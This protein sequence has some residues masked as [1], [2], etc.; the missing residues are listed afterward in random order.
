MSEWV[1]VGQGGEVGEGEVG[2]YQVKDRTV[3]VANVGGALHAFD[4]VCTHR[5][6]SLAEGELEGSAIECP[7][8]GSVFDVTTGEV[9][10]G[11]A[12]EP[13]ETFEVRAEGEDLQISLG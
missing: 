10:T 4:D 1:T 2:A 5:G 8:H 9:L 6:C 7:C 13:V 3:A 11:P 12:T